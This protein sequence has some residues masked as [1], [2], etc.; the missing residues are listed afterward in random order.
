MVDERLER[1]LR[2]QDHVRHLMA[3]AKMAFEVGDR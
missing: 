3:E 1:Y 2:Q